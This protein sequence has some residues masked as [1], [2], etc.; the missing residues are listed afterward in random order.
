[1]FIVYLQCGCVHSTLVKSR[2]HCQ[3]L[4]LRYAAQFLCITLKAL[5]CCCFFMK[6]LRSNKMQQCIRERLLL[7]HD[8]WQIGN[9]VFIDTLCK[10]NYRLLQCHHYP[11]STTAS[12][13]SKSCICIFLSFSGI[14]WLSH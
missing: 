11:T 3:F 13:E 1:M 7:A 10:Y 14:L 9:S 4:S 6:A 8:I 5:S 12:C 2:H